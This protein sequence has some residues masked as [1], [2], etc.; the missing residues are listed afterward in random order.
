MSLFHAKM[1]MRKPTVLAVFAFLAF[2]NSARSQ[3]SKPSE[4]FAVFVTGLDEAAPVAQSLVKKL[5]DS[6]PFVAVTNSDPSKVAVLISCMPRKQSG[7]VLACMYVAHYVGAT[8]KTFLGGGMFVSTSV[9]DL[10]GNKTF[11]PL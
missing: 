6:K 9:D 8:C 5:N 3:D 7:S 4:R 1:K 2:T 11:F 10:V